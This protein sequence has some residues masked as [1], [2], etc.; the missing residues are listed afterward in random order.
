MSSTLTARPKPEIGQRVHPNILL[1]GGPKTGKTTGALSAPGWILDLNFDMPNATYFARS[2][3][4]EDRIFEVDIPPYRE[5]HNDV[6]AVLNEVAQTLRQQLEQDGG[7]DAVV[8]D[9]VHELHRRLMD[10]QSRRAVRPSRDTYGDVAKMIE[11]FCRFL[12]EMPAAAIFVCHDRPIKDEQTGGFE[13]LPYT[14]TSNPDLGLK[15]LGMVDIV[16]YTGVVKRENEKPLYVAQLFEG[17]GRKGGD[18]F[19]VLAGQS[20]FRTLDL[21]GWFQD[22][23]NPLMHEGPTPDEP[24]PPEVN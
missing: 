10:E 11:R 22:I 15:L 16:A 13:R 2:R 17:D 20:G 6:D 8:V 14:G 5:G 21:A 24:E 19:G 12:C 1:Y 18:R 3:M 9:P 23:G 7:F 4:T